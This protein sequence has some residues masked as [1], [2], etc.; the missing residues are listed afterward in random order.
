MFTCVNDLGKLNRLARQECGDFMFHGYEPRISGE[1]RLYIESQRQFGG[2]GPIL[3]GVSAGLGLALSWIAPKYYI[4]PL[5]AFLF[6][7]SWIAFFVFLWFARQEILW[8]NLKLRGLMDKDLA[9]AFNQGVLAGQKASDERVKEA[10]EQGYANGFS[11]GYEV[12]VSVLDGS[13]G[14]PSKPRPER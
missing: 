12:G 6:V 1:T 8:F 4:D 13:A 3:A 7:A 5:I 14:E 10:Q 9:E 11:E 2:F